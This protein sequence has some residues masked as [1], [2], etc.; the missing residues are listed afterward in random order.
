MV[1]VEARRARRAPVADNQKYAD[2]RIVLERPL[3]NED[4]VILF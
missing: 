4:S 1:A 3:R 2:H